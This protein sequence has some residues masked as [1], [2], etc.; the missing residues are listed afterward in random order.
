[1][2]LDQ[3]EPTRSS[4]GVSKET[5]ELMA[6][7]RHELEVAI[8]DE[9]RIHVQGRHVTDKNAMRNNETRRR[10]HLNRQASKKLAHASLYQRWESDD[11]GLE[12]D[13]REV[14]DRITQDDIQ[15]A[16]D[17]QTQHKKY[18]L[19]LDKLGPYKI[20]FTT[21]GTHLLLA[22]LRGHLANIR[23]K[24]FQLEGETQLKDKLNDATF[25]VDHTMTAVAQKR[26][27]YMYTKEGTEMH[28]LSK[29]AHMDRL[30]YLP[31]HM[32][33]VAT[34]SVFS[35]MQYLDISTGVELGTKTPAIMRDPASCLAVNPGNGVVASCDLR[36]VLKFWSPTV[37]DPLVQLKA[38]KGVVDDIAFHPNGRFFLTLGGDHKLKVWDCRT[39][40]ALEEYAITYDF[41]TMDISAK[42]LVALGGGTN[43]QIWRD[44]FTSKKPNAPYMK[45]GLGYG[46]IAHHVKFCPFEDVLGVGHTK[47]FTSLLIPGSGE[48]NPDF[49][50]AN[51]H[52][53]ERHRKER[54][55][56][57]LL[58][59]LPPDTISMD[60]QIPGVDEVRLAEYTENVRLNRKAKAIREK[61]QRRVDRQAAD[62]APTG[63]LVGNEEEVDE[64]IGYKEKPVTRALKTKQEKAKERKMLRWDKKD[65]TDKVRSKQTMRQSRLVQQKRTQRMRE[66][67]IGKYDKDD[68]DKDEV[69]ALEEETRKRKQQ[70]KRRRKEAESADDVRELMQIQSG[71][72]Q[73]KIRHVRIESG[74][75]ERGSRSQS[76]NT[77]EDGAPSNAALKRL[78]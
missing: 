45:F 65:S 51:P 50:Y 32:L 54:V 2:L 66:E 75:Q 28:I 27:V 19:L 17:I 3:A 10:E 55:V 29:F 14:A 7:R 77:K 11:T 23:W 60:V 1:M 26:Y 64:E 41:H 18:E 76:N 25:L 57:N 49:F 62:H 59:K 38:H 44:M 67:R 52:E 63:L 21:N 33:L 15:Q 42:G 24:S 39:L 40:R 78:L 36:G 70:E 20:N 56:T 16:V 13:E 48:P 37:L 5:R 74:T 9:E 47:G 43:I 71:K 6:R 22:G 12:L 8:H 31:K 4:S 68:L 46:K 53:T 58:D 30:G 73:R 69:E 35:V 72:Q 61:K 34:S